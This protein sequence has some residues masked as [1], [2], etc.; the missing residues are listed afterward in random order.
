[1]FKGSPRGV[2]PILQGA[3][4][5]EYNNLGPLSWAEYAG[6]VNDPATPR[7]S[8]HLADLLHQFCALASNLM[9]ITQTW[10]AAPA[11]NRAALERCAGQL[12]EMG[13][14]RAIERFE[15]YT[16]RMADAVFERDLPRALETTQGKVTLRE[17]AEVAR[18]ADLETVRRLLRERAVSTLSSR[19]LLELVAYF[20]QVLRAPILSLDS[21]PFVAL[22]IEARN[23]LVHQEGVWDESSVKRLAPYTDV[24]GLTPQVGARFEPEIMTFSILI[25]SLFSNARPADARLCA[26]FGLKCTHSDAEIDA[27]EQ[28]YAVFDHALEGE[29]DKPDAQGA[30]PTVTPL[31]LLEA[32]EQWRDSWSEKVKTT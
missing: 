18:A 29:R 13:I 19:G 30:D 17:L 21:L 12:I 11:Q 9:V 32:L 7:H 16:L 31:G 4:R 28:N 22:Y 25:Y 5:L 6:E 27:I 23:V 15:L 2:E 14:C 1:M 8:S 20:E 26:H 24:V 10:Q 3:D